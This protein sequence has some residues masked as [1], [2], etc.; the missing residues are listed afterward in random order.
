MIEVVIDKGDLLA[1]GQ[2]LSDLEARAFIR[3]QLPPLGKVTIEAA[4]PYPTLGTALA[5]SQATRKFR[6]GLKKL[7]TIGSLLGALGARP[8]GG[9]ASTYKRTGHFGQMWRASLRGELEEEIENEASY[10]GWVMGAKQPYTWRTGWR[11][12]RAIMV[13]TLDQWIP[14]MEHRA[15]KLWNR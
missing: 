3:P 8:S 9:S 7:G 6:G 4:R 12:L 2:S 13:E 1:L 11:K 15:F 5:S 14:E 10:A